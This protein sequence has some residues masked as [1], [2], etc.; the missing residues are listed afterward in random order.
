MTKILELR[1]MESLRETNRAMQLN[2]IVLQ[3]IA[4]QSQGETEIL[5]RVARQTQKD[6]I[7]LKVLTL[8]ATIYLPATLLAVCYPASLSPTLLE[9]HGP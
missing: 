3:T 5:S 1:D 7:T 8:I 2:L 9:S 6:S 4:T